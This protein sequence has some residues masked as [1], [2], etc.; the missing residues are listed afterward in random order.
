MRFQF[1]NT[2]SVVIASLTQLLGATSIADSSMISDA[3]AA[4]P[5]EVLHFCSID[6]LN[7]PATKAFKRHFMESDRV[8]FHSLGA[9]NGNAKGWAKRACSN[10]VSCDV[11]IVN[12]D[13]FAGSK[14]VRAFPMKDVFAQVDRESCQ[15]LVAKPVQVF[16]FGTQTVDAST[17]EFLKAGKLFSS[18]TEIY[19][20]NGERP[21]FKDV[22]MA[23]ED[24]V[25]STEEYLNG[26]R[27]R[28]AAR[29]A[30]CFHY[31]SQELPKPRDLAGMQ[32]LV[33]AT[34]VNPT[35]G[36]NRMTASAANCPKF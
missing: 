1:L 12:T 3:A 5:M 16:F 4:Q 30:Q 28:V 33:A 22:D 15:G 14:K 9:P 18:L 17:Q 31:A 6:G 2:A 26:V 24:F 7:D 19:G 29:N 34:W 8:A 27:A 36:P 13:L 10:A 32:S 11:L 20:F 25:S 35:D 23:I 21:Q